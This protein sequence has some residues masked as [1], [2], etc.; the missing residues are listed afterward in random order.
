VEGSI[1][2]FTVFDDL[3]LGPSEGISNE[4]VGLHRANREVDVALRNLEGIKWMILGLV[5]QT[6]LQFSHT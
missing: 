3:F 5:S 1:D 6:I 4:I 2:L